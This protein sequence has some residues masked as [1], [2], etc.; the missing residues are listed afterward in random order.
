MTTKIRGQL[1]IDRE[2][3]VIY[4]HSVKTG[5]TVL[6]ICSLPKSIPEDR[7]LDITHMTGCN[8]RASK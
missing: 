2:R 7:P 1:E 3:G 4:S 8:W 6:R 5:F